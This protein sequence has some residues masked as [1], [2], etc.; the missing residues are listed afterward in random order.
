MTVVT[1]HSNLL[2]VRN[3]NKAVIGV[4]T[5]GKNRYISPLILF[6]LRLSPSHKLHNESVCLGT[7]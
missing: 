7:L 4:S 5:S 3:S 2:L 1:A 6:E